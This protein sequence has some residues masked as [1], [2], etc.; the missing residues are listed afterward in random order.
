MNDLNTHQLGLLK[1]G[2]SD[3]PSL[4]WSAVDLR[5]PLREAVERLDLSPVAAGALYPV[6]KLLLNPMLAALAMSISSLF[7]VTNSLRL[8][9]FVSPSQRFPSPTDQATCDHRPLSLFL[10]SRS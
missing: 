9:R 8:R 2:F 4:R 1:S 10:F 6:V 5:G 7:V 3:N